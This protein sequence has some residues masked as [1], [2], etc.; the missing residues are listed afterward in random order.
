MSSE[1]E[2]QQ[3]PAA[4]PAAP[5]LSAADTKPGTTGSGAG[6]GGPGGLTSAVPAGGDKKVIGE[7]RT[8]TGVGPYDSLAAEPLPEAGRAGGRAAGGD[9]LGG[10]RLPLPQARALADAGLSGPRARQARARRLPRPCGPRAAARPSPGPSARRRPRV[11][12]GPS[13]PCGPRAPGSAR[14]CSVLHPLPSACTQRAR[15]VA[16]AGRAASPSLTCSPPRIRA[17]CL[18][19]QPAWACAAGCS[20]L[21]LTHVD[22]GGAVGAGA[23]LGSGASGL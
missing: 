14:C 10:A 22:R 7:G 20:G 1:A 11:R 5:A 12:R 17:R 6:S 13:P 16:Y 19:A 23:R 9:P 3:P 15:R 2:T 4:P 21:E 18:R 8:G